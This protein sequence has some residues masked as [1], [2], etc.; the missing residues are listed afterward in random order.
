MP[1]KTKFTRAQVIDAA[2]AVTRRSG[3]AS[4]TA[5]AVATELGASAKPIFGLFA[6]MEEV[7]HAVLEAANARFLRHQA[8]AMAQGTYPPYKAS[9]MAYIRFAQ[10]EPQLFRLL[11]MRDRSH[12]PPAPDDESLEPL[13]AL[14]RKNTGLS[15]A[16]ARMLHLETWIFVH[17]IA[18]MLVTGYL[19]CDWSVISTTVTDVYEGIK[20]RLMQ[21]QREEPEHEC[22]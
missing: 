1:P 14:I 12:E 4:V 13:I 18:S 10:E 17:G 7:Q 2:M 6:N 16:R 5:R 9:G 19:P 11:F 3:I 22:H 21:Q 20:L 8:E 15:D